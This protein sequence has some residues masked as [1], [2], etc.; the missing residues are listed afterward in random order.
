MNNDLIS[1]QA[2]IYT[3]LE[4]GQK[5]RRYKVGEIWELNFDEIREALATV[6]F[7]YPKKGKWIRTEEKYLVDENDNGAVYEYRTTWACSQCGYKRRMESKPDDKFC[8]ECGAD[9]RESE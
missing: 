4:K 8:K 6:P 9:M 5:S 3:L 7:E 2:A 1:R